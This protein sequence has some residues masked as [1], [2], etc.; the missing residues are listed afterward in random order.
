MGEIRKAIPSGLLFIA[1]HWRKQISEAENS[2]IQ[3]FGPISSGM[4]VQGSNFMARTKSLE[5]VFPWEVLSSYLPLKKEAG[6]LGWFHAGVSHTVG[7]GSSLASWI[8]E[9]LIIWPVLFFVVVWEDLNSRGG[10]G[11][12]RLPHFPS[13]SFSPHWTAGENHTKRLLHSSQT[14][15][16]NP[17]MWRTAEPEK[18]RGYMFWKTIWKQ[19]S[20]GVFSP[21]S[22]GHTNW[23]LF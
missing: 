19:G 20:K 4:C 1:C 9:G 22:P 16:A 6:P 10:S 18:P 14:V 23:I 12:W 13:K 8:L 17:R 7:E 3:S 5:M 15:W 2:D 21:L 11:L